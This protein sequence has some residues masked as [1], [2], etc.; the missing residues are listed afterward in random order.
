[1]AGKR[2]AYAL[3]V[4]NDPV[5]PIIVELVSQ[6]S[7]TD[8]EKLRRFGAIIVVRSKGLKD[9]SLLHILNRGA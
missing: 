1:M 8:T 2:A 6:G 7:D 5:L 4:D 9:E 3:L